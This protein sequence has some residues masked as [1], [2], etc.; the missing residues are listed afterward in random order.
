M[1]PEVK[2]VNTVLATGEAQLIFLA[3][4]EEENISK[5]KNLCP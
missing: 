3:V 2:I 1:R 5:V 4:V